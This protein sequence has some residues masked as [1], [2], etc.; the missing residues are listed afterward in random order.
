M[1]SKTEVAKSWDITENV[2]SALAP[3]ASSGLWKVACKPAPLQE[4]WGPALLAPPPGPHGKASSPERQEWARKV[5]LGG[6][7]EKM[8]RPPLTVY[9]H[10][11][12]TSEVPELSNTLN[13]PHKQDQFQNQRMTARRWQKQNKTITSARSSHVTR[14]L[15]T[16]GNQLLLL[17]PGMWEEL[18]EACRRSSKQTWGH[19]LGGVCK[20]LQPRLGSCPRN[21]KESTVWLVNHTAPGAPCRDQLP[22]KDKPWREAPRGVG[23]GGAASFLGDCLLE[24]LF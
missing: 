4:A 13:L 22:A 9:T 21:T 2:G 17:W 19:C 18:L 8:V 1:T 11:I 15:S 20:C 24:S 10:T 6:G 12:M 3:A 14:G 16:H 7:K 23:S 5:R